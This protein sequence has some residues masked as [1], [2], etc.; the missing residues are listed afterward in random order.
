MPDTP[1]LYVRDVPGAGAWAL[2]L[3]SA[4]AAST[5]WQTEQAHRKLTAEA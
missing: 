4:V 1:G 3:A 5:V 2:L